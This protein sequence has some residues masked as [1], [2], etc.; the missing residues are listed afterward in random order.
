MSLS[1]FNDLMREEIHVRFINIG[2]IVD[3]HCLN[4][5]FIIRYYATRYIDVVD[6]ESSSIV[7]AKA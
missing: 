4:F 3:H 1:L 7:L 5:I 6:K 2:E